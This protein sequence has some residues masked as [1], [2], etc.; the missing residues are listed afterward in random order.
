M[1][2]RTFLFLHGVHIRSKFNLVIAYEDIA[3]EDML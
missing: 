3:Y 2:I 1:L